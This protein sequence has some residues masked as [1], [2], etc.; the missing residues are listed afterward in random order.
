MIGR[1]M[2]TKPPDGQT[3]ASPVQKTPKVH[4]LMG[5]LQSELR[6]I[7]GAKLRSERRGHTLQPTALINE[8]F[9][10]LIKQYNLVEASKSLFLAAAA[11]TM[12][13]I[14]IEYARAYKAEKRGHGLRVTLSGQ[15]GVADDSGLEIL[16]LDDALNG[17]R[18][19]SPRMAAVV[20]MRYFGGFTDREIGESLGVAARTVRSE[21]RFA[22]AWLNRAMA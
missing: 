1:Y 3:P 11:E 5:Q 9:V 6:Q 12:R 7:A 4:Q 16:A 13:R 17:L 19:H 10:R 2:A 18:G 15:D 20:E 8:A 14:L 21:W 22:R